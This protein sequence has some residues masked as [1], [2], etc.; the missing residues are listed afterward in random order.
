MYIFWQFFLN[1]YIW[2]ALVKKSDKDDLNQKEDPADLKDKD[3]IM[4][5]AYMDH[6]KRAMRTTKIDEGTYVSKFSL[7]DN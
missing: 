5:R 1:I 2:Q 6:F 3:T 7:G 4:A